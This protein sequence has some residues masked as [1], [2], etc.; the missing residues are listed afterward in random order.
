M[1]AGQPGSCETSRQVLLEALPPI[2]VLHLERFLYDLDVGGVVKMRKPIQFVS[3]LEIPLGTISPI[4][5][6][7]VIM[8]ENPALLG[9]FRNHGTCFREICRAGLL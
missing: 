1:P 7:V 2:L 5:S 9:L 8:T 4:D 3:E 6:P